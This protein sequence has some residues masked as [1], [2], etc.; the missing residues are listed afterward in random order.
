MTSKLFS[1]NP[2]I[3][4]EFL[5]REVSCTANIRT[6]I[7]LETQGLPLADGTRRVAARLLESEIL[8]R[9]FRCGARVRYAGSAAMRRRCRP[10]RFHRQCGYTE[11]K[12]AG[13]HGSPWKQVD[14]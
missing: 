9:R 1:E 2:A 11:N 5:R 13:A 8:D 6:K 4:P 7:W 3:Q 10:S 12:R 14:Q